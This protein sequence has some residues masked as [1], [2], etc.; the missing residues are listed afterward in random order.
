VEYDQFIDRVAE[1]AGVSREHAEML[2]H[3]TLTVLADRISG[4][5]ALDLAAMLPEELGEHLRKPPS[6]TPKNY[7]FDEF[8][9]RVHDRAHV[10]LDEIRPGIRAVLLTLRET[11]GEKEFRDTLAQLPGQFRALL[12]EEGGPE[13]A[14]T[15]G[16]IADSD[17]DAAGEQPAGRPGSRAAQDDALV[18]RT[19]ERA[20]VS[21]QDAAELTRATLEV[22][23]DRIGG[24]QA[25]D[26]A[27]RLPDASGQW[28]DEPPETPAHDYGVDD[29]VSR[30]R[31]IV[32]QV[33]D[34]DITPGIQAV[35]IALRDAV[36]EAE[37]EIALRPLPGE[38]DELLV[39]VG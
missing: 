36:G 39:R 26:L 4:G 3:A 34:H 18:Q 37:V 17:S 22:L 16:Q 19:A 23:G 12:Q 32:T 25:R 6:K 20:G 28:L 35:M 24:Q 7:S 29:F 30:V 33:D 2:S 1:L 13:T 5:Q 14:S 21:A 31:D 8:V 15:G 11:A 9:V 27:Q 10:P 38:Y